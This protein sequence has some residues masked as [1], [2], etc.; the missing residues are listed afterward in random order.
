MFESRVESQKQKSGS[1]NLSL[2]AGKKWTK[3]E[4]LE[5]LRI[6]IVKNFHDNIN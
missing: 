2:A 1:G 4:V 5:N 6:W 3:I